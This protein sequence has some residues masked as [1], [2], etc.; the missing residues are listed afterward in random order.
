MNTNFTLEPP[1]DFDTRQAA[2]NALEQLLR[3]T[4]EQEALR[5]ITA[6][7]TEITVPHETRAILTRTLQAM[8]SNRPLVLLSK[9]QELSPNEAAEFL[10]LSR[11]SVIKLLKQ[12]E[13]PYRT[14]G[15]HYR[16]RA[17]DL[18]A[19]QHRENARRTELLT[20]LTEDT[21]KYEQGH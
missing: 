19:Y 21:Q 15:T 13:L 17:A 12:N 2:Q 6:D 11:N 1:D 8:A 16:I 7:G 3:N 18:L 14:V 10:N 9:S 5:V 20:Q 4:S